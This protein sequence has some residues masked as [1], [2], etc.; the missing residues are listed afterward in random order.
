MRTIATA[1]LAVMAIV[2]VLAA[3]FKAELPFLA[4][5]EAF[6]EAAL[7]GGLADWFAV[8]ALFRYPGG[9]PFPHTAI[10]PNNKD[11]IGAQLGAFVEDNFLTP[12]NIAARLRELDLAGRLLR[13]LAVAENC[14]GLFAM[15][16]TLAPR[17]IDAVDDEEIESVIR[18]VAAEEIARLDLAKAGADV[19]AV[20]TAD[21]LHQRVLERIL[22]I[23]AAWLNGERSEIKRRFAKQS[24]LTP[25][26]FDGFVVNRFVDGMID[27]ID[28]IAHTP[29]HPMRVAFDGYV[30][31]LV[32]RLR[33][34]PELEAKAEHL[35]RTIAE[36]SELD[37]L[38]AI[39]W[40]A[41]KTRLERVPAPSPD[42]PRAARL[43]AIAARIAQGL[44]A[45]PAVVARLNDKLC[46]GAE[47]V[48]TQ[49]R[50]QFSLL[51]S[52]VVQRW[53]AHEVSDKIELE[54]GPDLQFV[55]LNGS[56]VGGCAGIALH[57]ILV[58]GGAT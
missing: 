15:F 6:S 40:N 29:D 27:L 44:L 31:A 48:L 54:I 8:V 36:S 42:A 3:R 21:R 7:I 57:A 23:V 14:R 4:W 9:I 25:G 49:F 17:L 50:Q 1:V 41:L 51:I 32:T 12:S 56:L 45:E 19:L 52:E 34:D 58:A 37:G 26:W 39:A 22:P 16:R 53:D 28:E 47:A 38:V 24:F 33:E 2:F 46:D 10:V 13:W 18:R 35:K 5:I 20:V 55:R 43:S 30:S 11:R